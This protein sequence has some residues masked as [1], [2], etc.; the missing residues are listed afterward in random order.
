MSSTKTLV[1]MVLA[2]A[3][4]GIEGERPATEEELD[5]LKETL[6]WRPEATH[7]AQALASHVETGAVD[8][9]GE[10]AT[11]EEM[12]ESIGK[13]SNWLDTVVRAGRV[14]VGRTTDTSPVVAEYDPKEEETHRDDHIVVSDAPSSWQLE[15]LLHEA[16]HK[17]FVGHDPEF[18]AKLNREGADISDKSFAEDIIKYHDYSYFVSVLSMYPALV[19]TEDREKIADALD[20]AGA[21]NTA[22][23]IAAREKLMEEL[24]LTEEKAEEG[25]R[26]WY[27]GRREHYETYGLTEEQFVEAYWSSGLHEVRLEWREAALQEFNAERRESRAEVIPR[28]I[29]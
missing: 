27:D 10:P 29:H 6:E 16:G 13:T 17:L 5:Q 9:T 19:A 2:L 21:D 18:Q 25:V 7:F 15:T 23:G 24:L 4:C 20:E 28:K 8:A 14:M 26:G 3:G 22:F 12:A 1:G 11:A